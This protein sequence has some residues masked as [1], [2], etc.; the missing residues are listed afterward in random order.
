MTSSFRFRHPLHLPAIGLAL[1]L[2]ASASVAQP[3]DHVS[4]LILDASGS[5]W[6]QLDDGK[7]KIEVARTVMADF[8]A[9]RDPQEPLGVIAY[10]HRQRGDCL[11][12]EVVAPPGVYDAANLSGH[13]AKI[14]PRGMTPISES[15]RIAAH[16]IPRTAERA[17][18]ILVTDGLETCDA[19]PCAMAAELAVQGVSIRAHVVGFG[20]T[21]EQANAMRCVA[22]TTGGL[23]LTPQSGSELSAALARIEQLDASPAPEPGAFFDIGDKAEA[24]HTYRIG[25]RGTA[26]PGNYAGFTRRGEGAPPSGPSYGVIGGAGESGNNPFSKRA[27]LEP[28]DYD[29]IL[30]G[31]N[32]SVVARQPIEVVA[33]SNGFEPVGS[34]APGERFAVSWR[35][36]NQASERVV[37]ARPGDPPQTFGESWGYP[38]THKGNMRLTAPEEAGFYELRYLSANGREVVFSRQFG[39]GIAY[40]DEDT[41]TTA[42][43]ADAAAASLRADPAQDALPLVR[44][45]FRIPAN[46]PQIALSWSAIPLDADMSPEAWAPQT[47]M[48]VGEGEFEPGRYEV[49]TQGPGEVEFRGEVEIVPGQANDF[50]IP[51]V[52]EPDTAEPGTH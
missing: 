35:G 20:L 5:M 3:S 13:L 42:Q 4:I 8:F 11:D 50:V 32:G 15:L 31:P 40:V 2:S 24:G 7:S 19:D 28:G 44:A 52:A 36:P 33:A 34:V 39:V 18:I 26:H 9:R 27:P 1:A 43:L 38:L 45:T 47:E 23:L 25:Y 10:G 16:Q 51:L 17:D 49:Y 41:T 46:F 12:I 37:I 48:I 6:G 14:S 21:T 22:D 30:A 29:L